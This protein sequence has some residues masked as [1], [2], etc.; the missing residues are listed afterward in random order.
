MIS[1]QKKANQIERRFFRKVTIGTTFQTGM[2]RINEIIDINEKTVILQTSVG[3]PLPVSRYKIRKAIAFLLYRRT[4]TRKELE[5][6]SAY[7]SALM[8]LL[9]RILIEIAKIH[10]TVKGLLRITIKGVR[11]FFSGVDRGMKDIERIIQHGGRFLLCSYFYL[12]EKNM[13]Q[14]YELLKKYKLEILLDS[15]EFSLY[16]AKRKGKEVKPILLEEYACFV[17]KYKDIIY[18]YFNLDVTG[19]PIQF[20]E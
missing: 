19:D 11:F 17:N 16:R 14:L 8:G 4:A 5:T 10:R 3:T 18:G 1:F 12:R 15:G 20:Q 7:N 6:F 9:Q 13:T 2:G